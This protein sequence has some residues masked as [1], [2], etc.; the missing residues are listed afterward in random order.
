MSGIPLE[1]LSELANRDSEFCI[2]AR[3]WDCALRIDQGDHAR[4]IRIE[5]GRI[6]AV[7]P[8][9]EKASWDLRIAAPPEEWSKLL[10]RVPRPFYQDLY[11][12]AMHH[13]F[14]L[15]GDLEH[16]LFP[17]YP[18]VRRLLEILRGVSGS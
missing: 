6:A 12:A 3:F 4:T 16:H 1:Q 18:A 11:G 7:E 15:H 8:S 17:Y 2:A 13:G 14:E 9:D 5:S 10:A